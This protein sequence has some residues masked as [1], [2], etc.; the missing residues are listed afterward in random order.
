MADL[1]LLMIGVSKLMYNILNVTM[2]LMQTFISDH[3][4]YFELNKN[5]ESRGFFHKKENFKKEMKNQKLTLK[6]A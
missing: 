2:F 3:K 1:L 4:M 5:T 6:K